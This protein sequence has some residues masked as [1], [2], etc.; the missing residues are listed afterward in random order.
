MIASLIRFDLQWSETLREA[1]A[2]ALAQRYEL[3]RREEARAAAKVAP[4]APPSASRRVAFAD[5]ADG[6]GGGSGSGSNS[7]NAAVSSSSG[8]GGSSG[9]VIPLQ[10][11]SHTKAAHIIEAI[12]TLR[13]REREEV[14]ALKQGRCPSGTGR[15]NDSYVMIISQLH[16]DCH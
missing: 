15:D 5:D 16:A 2:R 13:R 14:H 6:G 1:E 7:D 12:A 11:P 10:A 4:T 3:Q 9:S 8:S